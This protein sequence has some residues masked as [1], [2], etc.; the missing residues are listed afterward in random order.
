MKLQDFYTIVLEIGIT[1]SQLKPRSSIKRHLSERCC[2]ALG[3]LDSPGAQEGKLTSI[4]VQGR[5]GGQVVNSQ[6]RRRQYFA[7]QSFADTVSSGV[8]VS[9]S[10]S[11][12]ILAISIWVRRILQSLFQK[13]GIWYSNKQEIQ[14]AGFTLKVLFHSRT[15]PQYPQ[16]SNPVYN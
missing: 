6:L 4:K 3:A 1:Q 16:V 7:F 9:N 2:T 12:N 5:L 11:K 14:E 13:I 8:F 10:T 15:P